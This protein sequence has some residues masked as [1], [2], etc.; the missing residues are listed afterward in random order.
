MKK[1]FK[2]WLLLACILPAYLS[3]AQIHLG[4]RLDTSPPQT[5]DS[6]QT[7]SFDVKVYNLDTA[8]FTGVVDFEYVSTNSGFQKQGSDSTSGFAYL[9][10]GVT[11]LPNDS[12]AKTLTGKVTG[13]VF[14]SGPS[15]VVIW[16]I[17]PNV[18]GDSILFNLTVSL[19][20]G[21]E[22]I[23]DK[24]IRLI[25]INDE[26][27]LLKDDGVLLKQLR[28]YDVLGNEILNKLNPTT[29]TALPPMNTGLYFAEVTYNNNQRRVFRFYH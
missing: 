9:A 8:A 24:K 19:P 5:I 18:R 17:A 21:V 2:L 29:S 22:E 26:L 23:G 1:A 6:L 12:I 11:I 4:L 27:Q 25:L 7:F 3:K 10:N 28:V 16:P 20:N 14:L 15:V 13:P